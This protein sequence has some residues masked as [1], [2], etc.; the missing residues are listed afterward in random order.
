MITL[1]R[2]NRFDNITFDNFVIDESNKEIVDYLK[3][4][5]NNIEKKIELC[6]NV[7][8]SGTVGTGKTML[9]KILQQNLQKKEITEIVEEESFN[10]TDY[11]ITENKRVRKLN[12]RYVC[13]KDLIEELRKHFSSENKQK[14]LCYHEA[15]ILIVDEVGVQ[16]NTDN[17]RTTLYDL[18]DFRWQNYKPTIIISNNELIQKDKNRALGLNKILG[19]RILDRLNSGTTRYFYINSKSKRR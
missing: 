3:D 4:Y 7:I 19:S 1:K 18:F 15:D 16:Y 14:V 8:I 12:I 9:A 10:G 13:C 6:E 11:E 5:C 17:E 2:R